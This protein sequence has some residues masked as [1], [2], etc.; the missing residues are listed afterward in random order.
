MKKSAIVFVCVLMVV[1]M[2]LAAC[3]A[4]AD[5][6]SGV[7][8]KFLDSIKNGDIDAMAECLEPD[9]AAMFKDA[10]KLMGDDAFNMA[11][12][13]GQSGVD[14]ATMSYKVTNEKIDGDTATV[15]VEMTATVNGKEQTESSDMPLTK[16]D[17]KWYMSMGL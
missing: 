10:I 12:I 2:A 7:A 3:G 4:A 13:L 1:M 5:G 16:V 15:T 8:T 6:P 14:P 17:G 11:D 9:T